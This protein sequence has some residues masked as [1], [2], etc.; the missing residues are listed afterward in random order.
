MF[1]VS[2]RPAFLLLEPLLP[3]PPFPALLLP[4]PM[5]AF[6]APW[7]LPLPPG[8]SPGSALQ[9]A[10]QKL[11]E[12][13]LLFR[14]NLCKFQ[15]CSLGYCILPD[16]FVDPPVLSLSWITRPIQ[17]SIEQPVPITFS[18][19]TQVLKSPL[20]LR[21]KYFLKDLLT[22]RQQIYSHI[23]APCIDL[24]YI[25]AQ[26]AL[27]VPGFQLRE[28]NVF[29]FLLLHMHKYTISTCDNQPYFHSSLPTAHFASS[30]LLRQ[31]LLYAVCV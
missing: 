11:I 1:P 5:S 15:F 17:L 19:L 28:T 20:P 24:L 13:S 3:E 7:L 27:S 10:F 8:R 23:I 21:I 22:R 6:Q 2:Q 30:D 14:S 31:Y 16:S 26:T 25:Y 12:I 29:P 18:T 4:V 9:C